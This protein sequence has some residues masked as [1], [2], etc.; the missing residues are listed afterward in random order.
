MWGRVRVG[1]RVNSMILK[2][3]IMSVAYMV[4][5]PV[6]TMVVW[7]LCLLQT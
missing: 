4:E 6:N 2:I 5:L 7:R 3:P 1:F